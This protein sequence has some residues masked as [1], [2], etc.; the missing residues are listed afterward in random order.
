MVVNYENGKVIDKEYIDS[1]SWKC[2]K[3]PSGA[4]HWIINED[5]MECKYCKENRRVLVRPKP[6]M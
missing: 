5:Q 4:H 3:S 6:P 1:G 2:D